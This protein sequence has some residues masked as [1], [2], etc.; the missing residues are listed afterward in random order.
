MLELS[1]SL[2]RGWAAPLVPPLTLH[3]DLP[4]AA[5]VF[6]FANGYLKLG[7]FGVSKVLKTDEALARTH[8]DP[9]DIGRATP[10]VSRQKV[11]SVKGDG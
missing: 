7:D 1:T 8:D 9:F 3:R 4:K 6:M 5:N 10:G 2:V 11:G